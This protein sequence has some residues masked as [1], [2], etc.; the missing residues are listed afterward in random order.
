MYKFKRIFLIVADSVGVGALPDAAKYGDEGTNTFKH[1][2]YA[3]ADFHI[4]N[5]EKLGIGNITDINNTKKIDKP[6]A[7]FGKMKELSV[8]KDTL[9]GHWEIMG[10]KVDRPFPSFDQNGFPLELIEKLEKESGH[11]FI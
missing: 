10:L 11:K 1:L 9:T 4:P 6:L 5:L 7:S 2:S 8:G 3:K